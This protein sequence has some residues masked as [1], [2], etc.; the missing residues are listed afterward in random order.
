MTH[1]IPLSRRYCQRS[2]CGKRGTDA[3][4]KG[5]SKNYTLAVP[6]LLQRIRLRLAVGDDVDE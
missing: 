4:I 2:T 1:R 5:G 3:G 6:E